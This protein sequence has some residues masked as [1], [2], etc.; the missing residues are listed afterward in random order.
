MNRR[1]SSL[2]GGG[3]YALATQDPFH[4]MLAMPT[5]LMFAMVFVFYTTVRIA[6]SNPARRRHR[7]FLSTR[8]ARRGFVLGCSA[9]AVRP[10]VILFF[11]GVYVA[12]DGPTCTTIYDADRNLS[13]PALNFRRAFAFSLETMTTIGY[14]LPSERLDAL[15]PS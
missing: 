3:V 14:G 2:C 5:R 12:I 15:V 8:A 7:R 13:Q 11:A 6:T 10:Q 9:T 1:S 4:V